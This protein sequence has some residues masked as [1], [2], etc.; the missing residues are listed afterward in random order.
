MKTIK[1]EFL[2][3]F[4]EGFLISENNKIV[5]FYGL[6]DDIFIC[7]NNKSNHFKI[8]NYIEND[9]KKLE[10]ISIKY[11]SNFK[12]DFSYKELES[13]ILKDEVKL[14]IHNIIEIL[15][16]EIGDENWI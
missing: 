2:K 6:N 4:P 8:K 7:L 5:K 3:L 10:I 9:Y 16:F 11:N 12:N 15:L 14:A 13:L 1:K